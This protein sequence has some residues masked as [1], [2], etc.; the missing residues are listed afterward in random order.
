MCVHT[1]G[2]AQVN[3]R[4]LFDHWLHLIFWESLSLNMEP[5]DLA[6]LAGQKA[7]D[8]SLFLFPCTIIT[9]AWYHAM[10][11]TAHTWV[12]E[13]GDINT[14]LLRNVVPCWLVFTEK[15]KK[16]NICL[17]KLWTLQNATITAMA[18]QGFCCSSSIN[19]KTVNTIPFWDLGQ[20]PEDEPYLEPWL[21]TWNNY[22]ATGRRGE[23]QL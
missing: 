11:K 20:A 16:K 21:G 19:I 6:T 9:D 5:T 2:E 1:C 17:S 10:Q 3:I 7:P 4:Y 15:K 12:I 14:K 8:L 18:R 13:H 23:L 22:H